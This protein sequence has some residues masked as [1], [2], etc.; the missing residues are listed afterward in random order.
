MASANHPFKSTQLR[1]LKAQKVATSLKLLLGKRGLILR[2][3]NALKSQ[4]IPM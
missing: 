1:S 3:A 2:K 4:P